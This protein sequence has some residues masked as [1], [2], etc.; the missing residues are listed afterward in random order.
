VDLAVIA[1]DL[2]GAADS[3]V[4]LTRSGYRTAVVFRD[5]ALPPSGSLDA[6]AVDTDSRHL[7]TGFA[8]KRVVEAG[9]A[10]RKA[11][12][13]YK[14]IDST[15]RGQIPAELAAALGATRRRKAV[16]A[17]AFPSAG[18]TMEKGVLLVHGEPAHKTDLARDPRNPITESH[19]PSLLSLAF[20]SIFAL[21]VADVREGSP[22]QD[23]LKSNDCV[24]AD[25]K[26]DADLEVLVRNVSDPSS[27]LWVGSAGLVRALGKVY[28]GLHCA[29]SPH[30]PARASS[31]LTVVGSVNEVA[32]QQL[33]C[34]AEEAGVAAVILDTAALV[35]GS[36]EEAV[37]EATHAVRKGLSNNRGVGL[38]PA[39]GGEVDRTFR[40]SSLSGDEI[41]ECVVEAL[42]EVVAGL[43][44]EDLFD[45]LVLT[46]GDTAVRV[47]RDLGAT[48]IALEG[49]IEAGV[50]LG[51]LVGPR[52]YRVVTKAGGFGGPDTLRN[53]FR[54]LAD[55]Q[56]EEEA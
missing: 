38:Y 37:N 41:S 18:R 36:R 30:G 50:P 47:A 25:A 14:K 3:G 34:L 4:Q 7:P 29:A 12:I 19:V 26:S 5:A 51:T 55:I 17:P 31:V 28:P 45:A 56:K 21:P 40:E 16:V 23:A 46:G 24:V 27:V 22:V 42:A 20:H 33:R 43:S 35:A 53:T 8:A 32:R 10:V 52:P 2:T 13:V 49:E 9:H 39:L 54:A 48:G 6:V 11:R 1:D 15:L 44:V